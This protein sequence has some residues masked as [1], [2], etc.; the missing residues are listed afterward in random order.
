MPEYIKLRFGGKRLHIFLAITLLF[1][2]ITTNLAGEMYAG[3]ILIQESLGWPLYVSVSAI[4]LMTAVYTISGGLT[5][6]VYTDALQSI[7][8]IV[9]SVILAVIGNFTLCFKYSHVKY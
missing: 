8:I 3:V 4:L 5:A 2:G 9:G 7:L 1:I 6:V